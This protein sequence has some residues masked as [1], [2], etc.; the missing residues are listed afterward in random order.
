MNS[1]LSNSSSPSTATSP[2]QHVIESLDL[3]AGYL[4]GA[5]IEFSP[6][7]NCIIGGRGAG[8]STLVEMLLFAL[9]FPVP[10]SRAEAFDALVKT[11][12]GN[13]RATA[14]VRNRHGVRYESSRS[15]GEA[16][17]VA[18][19]TGELTGV[20]LDGELFK[21][22]YYTPNQIERIALDRL[23]QLAL[24]DKFIESDVRRIDG[25]IVERMRHLTQSANEVKRLE[26][27]IQD[28]EEGARA[29][30]RSREPASAP[31]SERA[32]RRRDEE[33]V[34]E[35]GSPHARARSPYDRDAAS[36]RRPR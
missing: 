1:S 9:G 34:R 19:S 20:S 13:G 11:N 31:A 33:G 3:T 35:Q 7:L 2:A 32:R 21:V 12:L 25:A 36:R 16:L 4:R 14:R 30:R 15:Y 18:S 24:I 23:A 8:K 6:R 10:R 5:R 29:A 26:R 22:D 28:D 27:E 17:R